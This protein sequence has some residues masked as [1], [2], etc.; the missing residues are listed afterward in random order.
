LRGPIFRFPP[1]E[2]S[3]S[4]AWI[5][6]ELRLCDRD[7]I[8]ERRR[9]PGSFSEGRGRHRVG[10]FRLGRAGCKVAGMQTET[11]SRS[12]VEVGKTSGGR[13]TRI[14]LQMWLLLSGSNNQVHSYAVRM[15]FCNCFAQLRISEG[16]VKNRM[17][18]GRNVYLV[19]TMRSPSW[20]GPCRCEAWSG[21]SR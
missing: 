14:G 19:E 11:L 8:I 9:E 17:G 1:C 6:R 12:P 21:S 7:S 3:F 18:G 20:R 16:S 4:F 2:C 10:T 15:E 13:E 5:R